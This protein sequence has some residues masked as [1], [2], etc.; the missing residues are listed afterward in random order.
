MPAVALRFSANQSV[1]N[2]FLI[3]KKKKLS[4]LVI[5]IID[6]KCS[7]MLQFTA[8]ITLRLIGE[9]MAAIV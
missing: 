7:R 1:A 4:R 8:V 5:V 6:S 2:Y 9:L 3:I